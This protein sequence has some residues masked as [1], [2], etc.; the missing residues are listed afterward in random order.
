[1]GPRLFAN[2]GPPSI[3]ERVAEF[4][5][6]YL[7][8]WKQQSQL[9]TLRFIVESMYDWG[10]VLCP[11]NKLHGYVT[12]E[13]QDL[14]TQLC[15]SKA[16]VE[17]VTGGLPKAFFYLSFR[18]EARAESEL[19]LKSKPAPAEIVIGGREL[20]ICTPG[21]VG[22]VR[23]PDGNPVYVQYRT[24]ISQSPTHDNEN[25]DEDDDDVANDA[26]VQLCWKFE[27]EGP[28]L[29]ITYAPRTL[30]DK[31][32]AILSMKFM[33]GTMTGSD[34]SISDIMRDIWSQ[35]SKLVT[36]SFLVKIMWACGYVL[37]P[38]NKFPGCSGWDVY[39]LMRQLCLSQSDVETYPD[40]VPNLPQE[41]FY[42]NFRSIES[43][44]PSLADA[45]IYIR[46]KSPRSAD[47]HPGVLD[48]VGTVRLPNGIP[49]FVHYTYTAPCARRC[50]CRG[51]HE[52]DVWC[53]ERADQD[54]EVEVEHHIEAEVEADEHAEVKEH[55]ERE[56]HAEVE[57]SRCPY[58]E[59]SLKRI[60]IKYLKTCDSCKGCIGCANSFDC[61][62]LTEVTKVRY[63][64]ET[65]HCNKCNRASVLIDR[66]QKTCSRCKKV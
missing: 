17:E 22:T 16:Y 26:V 10:Y 13:I 50:C 41:S 14:I 43:V 31:L 34:M 42:L 24:R 45:K 36:L 7:R 44:H 56:Q 5:N 49:A 2:Y 6:R 63:I 51:C 52:A 47:T 33:T 64:C 29:L 9:L 48:Y 15:L 61:T 58:C 60:E 20:H 18:S 38:V 1:M 53:E 54:A 23:L 28:M 27:T 21:Y 37:T 55:A 12:S 4:E 39:D 59:G 8:L 57:H 25:D 65:C 46:D 19:V 30:Y 62:M 66:D 11:D 40:P 32:H 35:E 3:V